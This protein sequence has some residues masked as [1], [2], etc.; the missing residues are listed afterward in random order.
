MCAENLNINFSWKCH[1]FL[2]FKGRFWKFHIH[3]PKRNRLTVER[4]GKLVYVS[5]NLHL[6]S[7]IKRE[8]PCDHP[9][10]ILS[11]RLHHCQYWVCSDGADCLQSGLNSGPNA[12]KSWYVE[13]G[14]EAE[15]GDDNDE[16]D[17]TVCESADQEGERYSDIDEYSEYSEKQ[18]H[19]QWDGWQ[20]CDLR[21]K[22]L[23]WLWCWNFN[24]CHDS[25]LRIKRIFVLMLRLLNV[26]H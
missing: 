16:A 25:W 11:S 20:S 2:K 5:Q 14:N 9:Q 12:R 6:C 7:P 17:N 22:W 15:D 18:L 24:S 8:Q 3:S 19:W 23:K 26:Q 10:D 4:A 13:D 1:D 21:W